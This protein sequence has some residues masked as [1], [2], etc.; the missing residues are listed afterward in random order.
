MRQALVQAFDE[1]LDRLGLI[2]RGGEVRLELE[3]PMFVA[4]H[5]PVL[6]W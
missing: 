1:L 2:A 4:I 5:G 3:G 6:Y